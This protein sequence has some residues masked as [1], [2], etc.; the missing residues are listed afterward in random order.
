MRTWRKIRNTNRALCQRRKLDADMNEEMRSHVEM[1]TQQNIDAGMS[2]EESR[3]AALRQFGWTESIK[4]DC[5]EQ[6]GVRWL[7][8]LVQDVRFAARQL[9]KNPGFA[10]VAILI[11]ALG[12]SGVTTMFSTLYAVMIRPL[13]YHNSDRLV[14]G[15]ATYKG[16]LNPWVAGPDYADYR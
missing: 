15:R 8:D 10:S 5:R 4:E 6:R 3:F 1:R 12:I 7:E 13:P 16:E 11:L 14:L 9:C 2:P